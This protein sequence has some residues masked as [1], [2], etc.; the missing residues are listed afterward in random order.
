MAALKILLALLALG[1]RA[2]GKVAVRADDVTLSLEPQLTGGFTLA[3]IQGE[4]KTVYGNIGRTLFGPYTSEEFEGGVE[5]HMG[6]A[7]LKIFTVYDDV[8]A[9]RG[10]KVRWDAG[11]AQRFEDCFDF[12][13]K[14]WY[15]GPMQVEQVYPI[16]QA[17]RVYSAYVVSEV[18]NAAIV[19]RYWLNSAGE[20]IYVHPEVPL[21]VD[22]H[23][24]QA[25]HICFG[26]QIA[27][28][29][30]SKRNH[31]ELSYD[32]WLL[33]N[34]KEAHKHAVA[35][36]LGKPS[37]LPD[38]RMVEH[39]IWSTW[40]QHGKN[41]NQNNLIEYSNAIIDHGFN[42]S[43]FEIDD[44]WETCYG[45]LTVDE[46]KFPNMTY[47]VQELKARGYRVTI[48]AHPFINKDCEPW[49]SE[50][51]DKGYLVLN[52]NGSPDTT[53]WDSNGTASAY[54]DFTN[55]AAAGWW[56]SRLQALLDTYGIDSVKFDAGESNHSPQV[57]V[58]QG[59][60]DLH[61][62]HIVQAFV[63]TC[64]E[65]G[66][67]IE[68]KVGFRTQELPIFVR[69]VDRDSIW[70]LNNGLSTVI[71]AALQMNLNGYTFVLPDMIGGNGFNLDHEQADEPTKDLFMRW[72]QANTF[73]PTMQFSFAPWNFDN[74]TVEISKKYADLHAAYAHDIW[75]AME[76]SVEEGAPVTAP[77][78]WLDPTDDEAL[79][80]WD[81]YLVGENI[82]VAPVLKANATSRDIYL[83]K[84][85]WFEEGDPERAHTGPTWLRAYKAP[86]DVLPYFVKEAGSVP[87]STTSL[88]IPATLVVFGLILQVFNI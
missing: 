11:P 31:T 29:Y 72:V 7:V 70:G 24:I 5:V 8:T 38:F 61:P 19:E 53:W 13:T 34:V 21:F 40:A 67:M 12:G 1:A 85:T 2:Q 30:S 88:Q 56:S 43:Q 52:E 60:I 15:G 82:L 54:V 77:L 23:N 74:E 22:Y 49:Y 87:D 46:T 33:K 32:F 84:G 35:N 39:P 55:P 83:P 37:D 9:A 36:Y 18:D 75:A 10:F 73:L 58:Q 66:N 4:E 51:L 3:L 69:M 62:H 14:H 6:S 65:F 20:Y 44:L 81:E 79:I 59:D 80:I 48:W 57:P 68:V 76:A 26:A 41:I 50:A 25:N 78:W 47:L 42:N 16:E 45:S 86:L 17:K 71:T 63:K 28:P 64:A 27:D